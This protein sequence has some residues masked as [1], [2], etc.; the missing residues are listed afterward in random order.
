VAWW[1]HASPTSS[2]RRSTTVAAPHCWKNAHYQLVTFI[3]RYPTGTNHPVQ[4]RDHICIGYPTRYKC[5]FR[6]LYSLSFHLLPYFFF[7]FLFFSFLIS[8]HLIHSFIH[9]FIHNQITTQ[10][11]DLQSQIHPHLIPSHLISFTTQ[12]G[13]TI[14]NSQE[15]HEQE[16]ATSRPLGQKRFV[17]VAKTGFCWRARHPPATLS[18]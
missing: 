13:F 9:S 1:V 16:L 5:D 7:R 2:A 18:Q 17:L 4:M 10:K 6:H 12:I 3:C 14:T 8:S 11:H 15:T